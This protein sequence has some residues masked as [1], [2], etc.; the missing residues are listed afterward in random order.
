MT[1]LTTKPSTVE[2]SPSI[3]TNPSPQKDETKYK[4]IAED[5]TVTYGGIEAVKNV[6]MK[7]PEKSV[8]ALIGPS[9][10]GKTTFLR[11]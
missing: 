11:C 8:T 10:C 2:S 9:G 3:A 6:T 1:A 5:V 7:F 4:M